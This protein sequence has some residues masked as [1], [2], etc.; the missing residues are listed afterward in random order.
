MKF[1]SRNMNLALKIIDDVTMEVNRSP[2]AALA[3]G[4]MPARLPDI[5]YNEALRVAALGEALLRRTE[6]ISVADLPGDLGLTFEVARVQAHT[7]SRAE[8]WYWL[9]VDIG[10][11][12]AFL[13]TVYG[14]GYLLNNLKP[15]FANYP[16]SSKGDQQR[17]LALVQDYARL[18]LQMEERTRGQAARGI[19]IPQAQLVSC[20]PLMRQS[21]DAA[22]AHLALSPDRVVGPDATNFVAQVQHVIDRAVLPAF[23]TLIALLESPDYV[24]EAPEEVGLGQYPGGKEV[25]AELVKLHTTLELT[26]EEVHARGHERMRRVRSE[27]RDL[28]EQAGFDGEPGAYLD[29]LTADR[30]WRAET[31]EEIA[32]FF[33]RYI[34][35]MA[36]RIDDMFRFRPKAG[37]GVKPLAPELTGSMT[38]GYYSMP[39]PHQPEGTYLFNAVNLSQAALANIGALNYHELVPGHH[40]HIAS[41]NE[42]DELHELRKQPSFTAYNEGWAEYAATLAGELGMYEEPADRFG[43]L[44]MDAFLTSRLVVDTGMNTLGWSLEQARAYMREHSFMSEREIDSETLRYACGIPGQALAYKLGDTFLLE[45][46]E[47]MRVA[48]GDDFDIRDFH[49][50]VLKPGALPL[51]LVARN[52]EAALA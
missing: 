35:R 4:I 50:I 40:F 20:A 21:R 33:Q 52:I 11:P 8:R 10:F 47:R 23:D 3:K 37:Y 38:F 34:D 31:P 12:V 29:A 25:Y 36:P 14:G 5:S 48:R 45:Q 28:L 43:R 16:L 18:V 19:V 22:A 46:R 24:G 30:A 39:S 44:M 6:A 7:W 51:P 13:P 9:I 1:D 15:I 2:L 32:A 41:Q 42:N 27:M 17:Y 49:D 26:P